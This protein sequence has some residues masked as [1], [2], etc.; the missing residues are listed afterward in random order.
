[1]SQAMPTEDADLVLRPLGL[2][3]IQLTEAEITA[4]AQGSS[5]ELDPEQGWRRYLR[6]LAITALKGECQR[7]RAGVVIGPELEPE[8]PDRLLALNGRATQL[9][10]VSSLADTADVP[11][12]PWRASET[13]PQLVLLAQ[14]DEDQGLVQFPGVLDGAAFAAEIR[15]QK[16]RA[17]ELVQL[18]VGQFRGGLERLWQWVT[19]LA[20]EA[21][22]RGGVPAATSTPASEP[23]ASLQQWLAQLLGSQALIPLPVMGTRG[24]SV[25]VLRLITPQVQRAEDG[26]A[27]AEA[28]CSTPTIWSE[29]PLAEV[30]I[31]IERKV[32]WQQLATR[33]NPI[34]GP[35]A[36]PLA[37]L[38]PGQQIT[39][40]L[41]P[42]GCTGGAYAVLSLKAGE[43]DALQKREQEISKQLR[44]NQATEQQTTAN[45]LAEDRAIAS[46]VR[47]RLWLRMDSNKI[48]NS[49]YDI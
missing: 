9:V 25:P 44:E 24:G 17:D 18:Q 46:E 16:T 2:E 10:C 6:A 13:A 3:A 48:L 29:A 43:C 32:V 47:A 39:I 23:L 31:E 42:W 15:K 30:V 36:W 20:P 1:M 26:S 40:R 19:L 33:R 41:R 22:P 28:V 34:E 45:T 27:F 5:V 7:R 12:A 11:V 35:I 37:A 49:A 38:Q 14:V 21:L 4:A 8:A